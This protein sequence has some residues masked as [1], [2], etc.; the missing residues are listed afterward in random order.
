MTE[1]FS[2]MDLVNPEFYV[3]L[4][5]LWVV[6]AIVFAETG[7]FFGFFLPGDSLLFVAGI[8]AQSLI[9]AYFNINDDWCIFLLIILTAIVAI[10]GNL[11]GYIIGAWSRNFFYHAKDRWFYKKKY[12]D[13][14][15]DFYEKHGGFA[16]VFA[17]FV[18]IV[19]TFVPVLAGISSMRKVPFVFYTVVGGIVWPASIQ[20]AGY[21]LHEFFLQQY[22][23]EIKDYIELIVIF[24]IL[25]TTVP[26][27]MN[28]ILKGRKKR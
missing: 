13:Q 25:I 24:I 26:V 9:K 18:P 3:T 7:F 20:S 21:Y 12:L 22:N 8:Y 17:R 5:G 27:V 23:I 4:G 15:H 1:G 11:L 2:W 28:L 19:R 6:L 14:A 10:L 16:V